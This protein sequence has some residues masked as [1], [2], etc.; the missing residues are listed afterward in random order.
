MS[1]NNTRGYKWRFYGEEKAKVVLARLQSILTRES[2][3]DNSLRALAGPPPWVAHA[4]GLSS[5]FIAAGNIMSFIPASKKERKK[6]ELQ[7]TNNSDGIFIPTQ[8]KLHKYLCPE[9]SGYMPAK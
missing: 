2:N 6:I 7:V 9:Q 5:A 8:S 3:G 1:E 4:N